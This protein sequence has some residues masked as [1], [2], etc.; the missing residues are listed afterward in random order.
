MGSVCTFGRKGCGNGRKRRANSNR[1]PVQKAHRVQDGSEHGRFCACTAQYRR[2][3]I[4]STKRRISFVHKG[5]DTSEE[6]EK[7]WGKRPTAK[8][9]ALYN[10][11]ASVYSVDPNKQDL[12]ITFKSMDISFF[13]E[14]V[15]PEMRSRRR[16]AS[17]QFI[18]QALHPPTP[19]CI[20]IVQ[21][22]PEI[23]VQPLNAVRMATEDNE[24]SIFSLIHGSQ[25]KDQPQPSML[26]IGLH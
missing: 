15:K 18:E 4:V 19:R 10:N 1:D 23:R 16:R 7:A 22:L 8:R 14:S 2:Q 26:R 3:N 13:S 9:R 25:E 5:I 20:G 6:D 12:Y 11:T 21:H 24:L 17:I